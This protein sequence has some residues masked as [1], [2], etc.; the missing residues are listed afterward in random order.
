MRIL[1]V[2]DVVGRAG[3]SAVSDHLPG[4]IRDW[5]LDLVIVNGENAAGG[6]GIT[7]AIYQELVDAGADAV[8]LGNHSWDQREALVF[9]ERAPRLVRP[10][11]YP[12]GT[13][14]RGAA[15]V[16]AKNG[17]RALVVNVLGRVFMTPFD[18]PFAAVGRELGAC[19]LHEAADAIVVDVHCEASSEKQGLGHFCDGR[20]SLVVGTHTHVPTADHQ[21]LPGGT[22]YMTDAGMTGDYDSIIGMQKDEP[23]RRFQSGIPSARFEPAM[24][25]ATLSGV[26]VE[27]DDATG[28]AGR[29]APV[30]IGGRLSQ[31]KPT[32]WGA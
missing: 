15:L 11:N 9:I 6:F 27:T 26:A 12:A 31:A 3:R 32:F 13:P 17:A 28:L 20:A 21:I 25:E 4:L 8:T 18:D 5:A 10:A 22:A 7:E 19:P 1:F 30:R 29:I 24:G 2:G 14:G 23:L 16:E